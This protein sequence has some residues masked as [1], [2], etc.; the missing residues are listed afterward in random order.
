MAKVSRAQ[1]RTI[2]DQEI[3]ENNA[4]EVTPAMVKIA[5]D[6]IIDS[7][8]NLVDDELQGQLYA[9]TQTLSEKFAEQGAGTQILLRTKTTAI[10]SH[11]QGVGSV[12]SGD[13]NATIEVTGNSGN[14]LRLRVTFDSVGTSNYIPVI[15]WEVTGTPWEDRNN[16]IMSFG[17]LSATGLDVYIMN[18]STAS[19][20]KVWVTLLN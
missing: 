8:F 15:Q 18:V 2:A 17:Q 5:L 13:S 14:S 1:E 12:V 4:K 19:I 11:T 3:Y 10:N 6:A 9:G 20:G 7:N 16:N